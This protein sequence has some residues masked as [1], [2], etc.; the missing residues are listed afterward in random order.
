MKWSR[1]WSITGLRDGANKARSKAKTWAAV[2]NLVVAT[3]RSLSNK[4]ALL[5]IKERQVV[6]YCSDSG[7]L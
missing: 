6:M 7:V 3:L 4:Q 2:N 1:G 5:Q